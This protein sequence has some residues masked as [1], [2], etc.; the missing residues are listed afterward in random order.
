MPRCVRKGCGKEFDA[1]NN[2]ND[3]CR[4]HPAGPIFHEG[5]K[6]W[7]CCSKRVT[8]FTDFLNI[9]GCATGAHSEVDVQPEPAPAAKPAAA[10]PVA[11]KAAPTLAPA[12]ATAAP[13]PAKPA[14]TL[15]PAAASAVAESFSSL[16]VTPPAAPATAKGAPAPARGQVAVAAVAHTDAPDAVITP[17][18]VCQ[19]RGCGHRF[20][21]LATSRENA[22]CVHHPGAPIFHEGSKGWSCCSRR[23]LEFDE[24]LKIKGCT[25]NNAHVFTKPAVEVKTEVQESALRRD[26]YQTR[27]T[28]VVSVYAKGADK[29]KSSTQFADQRFRVEAVGKDGNRLGAVVQIATYLPIDPE[30]STCEVLSTKIELVLKKKQGISWPA[31]EATDAVPDVATW[32][33]FGATGGRT[34][35]VGGKVM[36]VAGDAPIYAVANGAVAAAVAGK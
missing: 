9:P 7:S 8:D 24:F 18:T 16:S 14:P 34:G 22:R 4:F 1:A 28:V 33:T 30:K 15:A 2:T 11:D 12:A 5:L 19:R 6:G 36:D 29:T 31:L 3:A 25:T 21:D 26:W 35:T 10:K 23:V 27:D 20:V 32:T 13:A 17:G